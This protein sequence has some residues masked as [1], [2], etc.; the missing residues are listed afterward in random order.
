M[1]VI[2]DDMA[3]STAWSATS[4]TLRGSTPNWRARRPSR[5]TSCVARDVAAICQKE[6]GP[7]IAVSAPSGAERSDLVVTGLAGPLGQVLR[8]CSSTDRALSFSRCRTARCG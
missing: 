2:E 6:T 8:R 4:R 1:A 3:R 5:W 7:R